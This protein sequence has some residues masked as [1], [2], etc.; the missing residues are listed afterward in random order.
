M[1]LTTLCLIIL[2]SLSSGILLDR[3]KC[4]ELI[5]DELVFHTNFVVILHC[6]SF[7]ETYALISLQ[8]D[9][10]CATAQ[11]GLPQTQ[12]FPLL[13]LFV[14]EAMLVEFEMH[15]N[16]NCTAFIGIIQIH[17][18]LRVSAGVSLVTLGK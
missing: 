6:S 10:Y 3:S 9:R 8:R 12:N 14:L 15:S 5:T 2:I 17:T 18:K 11:P 4:T 13:A 16:S 1:K 7:A